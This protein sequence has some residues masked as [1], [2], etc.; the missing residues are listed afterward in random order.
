[1]QQPASLQ[2]H[3]YIWP[4]RLLMTTPSLRNSP[5]RH[6]ASSVLIGLE[7]PFV[8]GINRQEEKLV[9]AALIAPDVQQHLDSMNGPMLI[10]HVDPDV[11]LYRQLSPPLRHRNHLELPLTRFGDLIQRMRTALLH[12]L[13]CGGAHEL[14]ADI[15]ARV[16]GNATESRPLDARIG[17]I[18]SRFREHVP[19]RND[20][21]ALAAEAGFS[22]SP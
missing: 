16:R 12:P 13:D 1:M 4:G 6:L 18:T 9:E 19:D 5:H 14:V 3:C 2:T 22:S 20:P 17:R 7:K 10:L 15:V 8:L 11:A 21:D